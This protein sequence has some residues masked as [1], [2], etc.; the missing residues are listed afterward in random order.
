MCGRCLSEAFEF[1][2]RQRKRPLS[3]TAAPDAPSSSYTAEPPLLLLPH[4]D[5]R[6]DSMPILGR[7]GALLALCATLPV[8]DDGGHIVVPSSR[9]TVELL[10]DFCARHNNVAGRPASVALLWRKAILPQLGDNSDGLTELLRLAREV[11]CAPL[12]RL[13]NET[14]GERGGAKQIDLLLCGDAEEA[15]E[16]EEAP[17]KL[18]PSAGERLDSN[19]EGPR[20]TARGF[21]DVERVESPPT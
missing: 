2:P 18:L 1:A 19:K 16:P 17:T 4:D 11:G 21:E 12:E 5:N 10:C 9:G 20:R 13:C 6:E 8:A 7:R 14:I 15:E 3:A